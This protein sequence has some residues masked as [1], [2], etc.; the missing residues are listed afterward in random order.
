LFVFLFAEIP[1][2]QALEGFAVSGFVAGHLALNG[3][4]F[5]Q[6]RAFGPQK[7]LGFRCRA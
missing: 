4:P 2:Q 7:H 3:K 5:T 1:L 6:T